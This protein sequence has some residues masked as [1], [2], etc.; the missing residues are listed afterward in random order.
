MGPATLDVRPRQVVVAGGGPAGATAA[1][2]LAQQGVDVLL[3]EKEEMPRFHIGE[4]LMTETWWPLERLG[5][6]DWLRQSSFP[7]KYSVQFISDTGKPSRPFYFFETNSHESAVTWQVERS[8]FDAKLVERA[9]ECGVEVHTSTSVERVVFDGDR[10]TGV[11][12]RR[13]DE[14]LEIPSTVFVDATGLG[15]VLA[16]QLRLI[17]KDPK[18]RK[19]A[20]FAHYR[21]ALRDEGIDEG[22]TLI[23]STTENRG[24]FW[25][26]PLADDRV[27]VGVVGSPD[28]LLK[29]R[30]SPE[31]VLA[32]EVAACATMAERLA[33]A[34][35]ASP[36]R[37]VA[38]FS[39]RARRC[40][41]DGWVLVGDAFG[42]IDPVYSTGVFLALKSGQMA[43]DSTAAA[44][45]D[46][47]TT[48]GRLGSFAREFAAGMEA[49]RKLVHAFYTP[50]FSFANF[51]RQ[52]PEHRDRLVDL[53][54]GNVFKPGV[55][56]IFEDMKS[57]CDLPEEFPLEA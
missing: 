14:T 34:E 57:F 41:G 37:V 11:V 44:L 27:S 48:G 25:Y 17:Q 19:A 54:I 47:E 43:A 12:V 36:V 31:E 13:D 33:R 8:I 22:A 6:V 24:W 53:L 56:D 40:S 49:M 45:R 29:A 1:T 4:S 7:R 16:R 46:G 30:G 35:L 9:R 18:L 20:I 2:L 15:A 50:G 26:I 23:I 42:F 10:A 55:T 39:Y 21:G 52:H 5:L 28:D 32:E 38:D 3:V 51:V